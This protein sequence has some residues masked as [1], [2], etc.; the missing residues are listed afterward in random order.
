MRRRAYCQECA[1]YVLLIIG[2]EAGLEIP[3]VKK[4]AKNG[5]I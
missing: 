3:G 5:M 2:K 1:A 4:S